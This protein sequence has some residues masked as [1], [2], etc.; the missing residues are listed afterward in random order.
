VSRALPHGVEIP[1]YEL[2]H[3]SFAADFVGVSGTDLSVEIMA[4]AYGYGNLAL[5]VNDPSPD[6]F[7]ESARGVYLESE[8]RASCEA[9]VKTVAEGGG[10]S[11]GSTQKVNVHLVE[12]GARC[13]SCPVTRVLSEAA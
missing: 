4:D 12:V 5:A 1:L 8:H 9:A 6:P 11:R 13:A 3:D 7:D 2:N 10:A